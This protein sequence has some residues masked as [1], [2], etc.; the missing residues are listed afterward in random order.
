MQF[1]PTSLRPPLIQV[2]FLSSPHKVGSLRVQS[3]GRASHGFG[4]VSSPFL[5]GR[6]APAGWESALLCPAGPP[7]GALCTRGAHCWVPINSTISQ[8]TESPGF[9]RACLPGT[10]G[11]TRAKCWHMAPPGLLLPPVQPIGS[12]WCL[13]NPS[14]GSPRCPG[15]HSLMWTFCHMHLWASSNGS[16]EP[17]APSKGTSSLVVRWRTLE[18]GEP[19]VYLIGILF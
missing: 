13:P 18:P 8:L 2:A 12:L 15:S 1:M 19:W 9:L 3:E 10:R 6:A 7:R 11:A 5:P 14:L 16:E 17:L 4:P